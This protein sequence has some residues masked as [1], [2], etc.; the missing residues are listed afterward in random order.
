[1]ARKKYFGAKS[2]KK[3]LDTVAENADTDADA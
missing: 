3:N 1:L 2:K